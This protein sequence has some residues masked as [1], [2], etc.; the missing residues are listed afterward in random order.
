[1]LTL[2]LVKILCG[3]LMSLCRFVCVKALT[4]GDSGNGVRVPFRKLKWYRVRLFFAAFNRNTRSVYPRVRCP[5]VQKEELARTNGKEILLGVGARK[6]IALGR[7]REAVR[8]S[9]RNREGRDARR[10]REKIGAWTTGSKREP[11]STSWNIETR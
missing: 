6:F 4:C 9:R 8:A 5:L 11:S 2:S 1:M 7:R 10:G 3:M